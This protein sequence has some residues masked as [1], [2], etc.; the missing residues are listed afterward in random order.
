MYRAAWR[1][2]ARTV[3]GS[4]SEW[5][6]MVSVC[7]S[8]LLPILRNLSWPSPGVDVKAERGHD[9]HRLGT[10]EALKLA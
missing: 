2:M 5:R 3:P 1:M 6:V 10:G 8:P 9:G 7:F 4:S